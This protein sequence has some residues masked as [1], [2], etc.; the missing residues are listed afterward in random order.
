[1][2]AEQIRQHLERIEQ[3]ADEAKQAVKTAS[4]PEEVRKSVG[5]LHE[6]ASHAK[7]QPL[8][9]HVLFRETVLQLEELADDAMRACREA[10]GGLDAQVLHAVR[11]AHGELS[12]LKEEVLTRA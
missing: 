4:A 8:M 12:R 2:Q 3:Y 9:D 5:A 7:H 6:Q 11:R 1:M 10:G